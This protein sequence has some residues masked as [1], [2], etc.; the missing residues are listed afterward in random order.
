MG[1]VRNNLFYCY[2]IIEKRGLVLG[3]WKMRS[4]RWT[5]WSGGLVPA[6]AARHARA[7]LVPG[8]APRPGPRA[9]PGPG[10]GPRAVPRPSA[11]GQRSKYGAAALSAISRTL[12]IFTHLWPHFRNKHLSYHIVRDSVSCKKSCSRCCVKVVLNYYSESKSRFFLQ[13]FQALYR[14][15][16]LSI[17]TAPLEHI[18]Y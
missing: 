16:G 17:E 15:C 10:P 3:G 8:A 6:G 14:S 5:C 9:A 4:K 2:Y 12:L 1:F 7:A 13:T 18:C 11:R